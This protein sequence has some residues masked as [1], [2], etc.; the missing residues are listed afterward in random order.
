MMDR[1][2]L[3]VDH[4][5]RIIHRILSNWFIVFL[6]IFSIGLAGFALLLMV[7]AFLAE[8]FW[9]FAVRALIAA[10]LAW[11]PLT[12]IRVKF[13]RNIANGEMAYIDV[14]E[15]TIYVV[16][17][18]FYQLAYERIPFHG[19]EHLDCAF[20]QGR[21]GAAFL[22]EG[23]KVVVT[24]H[25]IPFYTIFAVVDGR[26][27]LVTSTPNRRNFNRIVQSLEAAFSP[28][29]S[30]EEFT[31]YKSSLNAKPSFKSNCYTF[32]NTD[33]NYKYAPGRYL[34]SSI[35]AVVVF[36][37]F[38]IATLIDEQSSWVYW[39]MNLMFLIMALYPLKKY[40]ACR[41]EYNTLRQSMD[42]QNSP[43]PLP[44]K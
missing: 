11:V 39:V 26:Q 4:R 6:R 14:A 13:N 31:V 40:L 23:E 8:S 15:K 9:M 16:T 33:Y 28:T 22:L 32:S 41:N 18:G 35:V 10:I 2:E 17:E 20:I 34:L 19:I 21:A 3:I 27:R 12:V 25:W 38:L 42:K 24:S 7:S 1:I 5:Q 43:R 44:Y 36:V 37:V 30:Y 29:V